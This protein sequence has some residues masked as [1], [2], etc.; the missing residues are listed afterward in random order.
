VIQLDLSDIRELNALLRSVSNNMNQIARRANETRSI[1]EA[2][3]RD[4]QER[5]NG[6][7]Q[8]A[9]GIMRELAKL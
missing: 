4:L 3:I 2:D 5:Y 8:K 1:Y 7:Y 6:L 9:D